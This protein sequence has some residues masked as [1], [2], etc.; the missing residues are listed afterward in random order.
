MTTNTS[1]RLAA[2]QY[3]VSYVGSWQH[4]ID[5][6]TAWCEE[7]HQHGAQMLVFPEYASMELASLFSKE[8]QAD[9]NAQIIAMQSLHHDFVALYQS[10]AKH[11]ACYIVAGS[12]PVQEG[13]A[14]VNRSYF[15]APDGSVDFQDKCIMTRFESE[16]WH[17]S[18]GKEIKVFDTTFGKVGIA[19]CYDS[20]F[21]LLSRKMVDLGANLILVPSCCDTFAGYHRVRLGSR[22]RAMEN[23]CFV[24]HA[25]LVGTADWS[26]AIDVNIG[27]AGIF[28]PVDLGFPSNGILAEGEMNEAQWVFADLNLQ[29]LSEVRHHGQVFNYRDWAYQYNFLV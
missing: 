4:Y 27:K 16:Q 7:A 13:D 23:Q 3:P 17:I 2:A 12:F 15:V 5:K 9:V 20:E 10:L 11:F 8:V 25:P 28:A 19:I 22:A 26:E 1:F 6:I 14:F 21:P 24:A 29:H 18:A